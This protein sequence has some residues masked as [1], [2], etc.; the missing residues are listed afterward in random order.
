MC[1]GGDFDGDGRHDA[2]C[3]FIAVED[4]CPN[5]P[6]EQNVVQTAL[7]AQA[8]GGVSATSYALVSEG[9]YF[10]VGDLDDDGTSDLIWA[11]KTVGYRL[12]SV[13]GLGPVVHVNLPELP[14]RH[15]LVVAVGDLDGDGDAELLLGDGVHGLIYD[16]IVDAP[17]QI[18]LI[19]LNDGDSN[20]PLHGRVS[21]DVNADG[22]SDLPIVGKSSMWERR[23][24]ISEVPQ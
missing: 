19:E 22:I 23:L 6:P 7:L 10:F 9:N 13:S 12:G 3:S 14:E 15:W 21:V 1:A 17:D 8:D 18:E 2:V 5:D 11:W 24:L 4:A 20:F 16:D